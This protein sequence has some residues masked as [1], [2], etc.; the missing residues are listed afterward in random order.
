MFNTGLARRRRTILVFSIAIF[1]VLGLALLT[2]EVL[3]MKKYT[4]TTDREQFAAYLRALDPSQYGGTY[5]SNDGNTL[6]VNVLPDK[7]LQLGKNLGGVEFHTVRYSLKQL[8]DLRESLEGRMQELNIIELSIDNCKNKLMIHVLREY[9]QRI[10]QE[11]A[12]HGGTEDM[13]EVIIDH[14]P[15]KYMTDEEELQSELASATE[16]S[17]RKGQRDFWSRMAVV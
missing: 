12:L 1:L 17:E 4:P 14:D 2:G 3:N 7:P 11:L 9:D 10:A 13:Y 6:N 5:S 15:I 8:Q 16:A